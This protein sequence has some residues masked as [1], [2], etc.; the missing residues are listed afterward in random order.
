MGGTPELF[1]LLKEDIAT[2]WPRRIAVESGRNVGDIA[3]ARAPVK[4]FFF[5]EGA[6]PVTASKSQLLFFCNCH[7]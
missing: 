2:I 1:G 7:A 5:D 3:P 6:L 4:N